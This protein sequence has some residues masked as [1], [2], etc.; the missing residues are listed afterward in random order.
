MDAVFKNNDCGPK[1]R[2]PLRPLAHA[3]VACGLACLMAGGL[4]RPAL[5][6]P[7]PWPDA[8]YTHFAQSEPLGALLG[9]FASNFGLTL[10]LQVDGGSAVSG[11][12]SARNPSEFL[13]RLGSIYG[14][15]W[16]THGGVLHVSRS[17][18]VVNRALALP[19][20]LG[21]VRQLL[22]DLGVL[23][24]RF[25][26]GELPQQG[27]VMVTGPA[28][29]VSLVETTL[30]QLPTVSFRQQINVYKLRYASADDRVIQHRDQRYVQSGLAQVIRQLMLGSGG[31]SGG[32][33]E[34]NGR[35]VAGGSLPVP[36]P[37]MA[38]VP[39]LAGESGQ[40]GTGRDGGRE[41]G[42]SAGSAGS[43]GFGGSGSG[44]GAS[45]GAPG[46]SSVAVGLGGSGG[47]AG[48][49]SASTAA[50]GSAA[51]PSG[52]ALP[53]STAGSAASSAAGV[54]P[55][56]STEVAGDARVRTP[57]IQSDSRLNALIIQD[58]PERM[59]LYERLIAQL[60]VPTPLIEIEAMIIDINSERVKELGIN[61]A[62]RANGVSIGLGPTSSQPGSGTFGLN[63]NG[64]S[65]TLSES[66]GVQLLAQIRVLE[67]RGE[68]RIQS[69]PSILTLENIGA[70]LDLSETFYVRVLG[71][72]FAS[73]S[74]VTAG[75]SLRVT[76][77]LIEQ[78]EAAIQ[79]TIDIEDGQIQDR[80]IDSLPTVRRSTV[81]TQAI[82]RQSEAL[83]IAGYSS[84]QNID[85]AQKVPLLGDLPVVGAL[86]ST[87]SKAVQKR[88]RLFIIRPKVVA[89]GS[90]PVASAG[91]DVSRVPG[92]ALETP[93]RR[94]DA[95]AR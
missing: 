74:P 60:D 16:Y 93:T 84:D 55:Q 53:G 1:G 4:P 66:A 5:A 43:G 70:L 47:P 75:T 26:W 27:L 90:T 76:P 29:Y 46:S 33:A 86:F 21:H 68:A 24:P 49:G 67:T 83:L 59:P 50:A 82:V 25:G 11:R 19:A 92:W 56:S 31:M 48:A 10:S 39:T 6:G 81:S 85:N 42:G 37:S 8:P 32:V 89:L 22:L 36:L 13:T 23:D 78:A 88:E 54:R 14:F 2:L 72:R 44:A 38:S 35:A 62:V 71:E 77:R 51:S 9:E 18:E 45:A 34:V 63:Y 94:G 40:A 58:L 69:R 79:M 87:R 64:S 65:S 15:I 20:G 52:L 73:V 57:S 7:V 28:S 80:Q 17:A 41:V 91:N 30:Q 61:W 3:L 95:Q 12:F